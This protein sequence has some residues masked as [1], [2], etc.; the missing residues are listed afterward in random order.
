MTAMQRKVYGHLPD[1]RPVHEYTMD[2]GRGLRLAAITYG[3][4]VTRLE[5]P[6]A[7]GQLAN[8]VLGLPTLE[9]YVLRNPHF[10]VIVGRYGN[11]I[12]NAAFR[13]DGER[14]ALPANDGA[15]CLHGGPRGFGLQ[16]WRAEAESDDCLRFELDSPDGD[17]GFPGRL[18]AV[19]RY[20]LVEDMGWQVEYE[21]TT[22]RPTVVNLTHHDYF[23]LAGHGS[24]LEHELQI[25]GSR[26][27]EIDAASIPTSIAP[28]AGT[29]FDFRESQT[30]ASRLR[31]G[32]PQLRHGKGYDHHWVLDGLVDGFVD[33]PVD[34]SADGRADAQPHLAAR[35]RDPVSGRWMEV[36]T[37]EP[38]VQ[39]YS[40]NFLDG[41]LLGSGG[42]FI[43][44]GDG[45]C[46]ETQHAPDS[47]N[48][49]VSAE[50]PSTVLRPGEVYRSRTLHRFGATA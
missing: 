46:L 9:D 31:Q 39:F 24:A 38:G 16:L 7:R 22:D 3:G 2:N 5:V 12:A 30:I 18:R 47:P 48:R 34:A 25:A 13:I 15:N 14:H 6:D 44:Q 27:C 19:V 50:W 41:S 11:R 28:V 43:R 20:R 35:L 29:P 23:N 40:G 21:A 10:G 42:E 8:V 17:Q 1:G 37:T 45:L 36:L 26:Y 33:A 49:A 32:H 4:I